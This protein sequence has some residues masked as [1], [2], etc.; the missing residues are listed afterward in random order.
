[1]AHMPD[2]LNE[3]IKLIQNDD[4]LHPILHFDQAVEGFKE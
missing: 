1:M 4:Y 2:L 3:F